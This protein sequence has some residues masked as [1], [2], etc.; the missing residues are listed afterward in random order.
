[1]E[2]AIAEND[3]THRETLLQNWRASQRPYSEKSKKKK[4]AFSKKIVGARGLP[5]RLILSLGTMGWGSGRIQKFFRR[6][7]FG[8]SVPKKYGPG[9]IKKIAEAS[10]ACGS[11]RLVKVALTNEKSGHMVPRGPETDQKGPKNKKNIS[12]TRQTTRSYQP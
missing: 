7:L 2:H 11:I 10:G 12:K 6:R 1:M 3:R 4:H 8:K 5:A 9:Q